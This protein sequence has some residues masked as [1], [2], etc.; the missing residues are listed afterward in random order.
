[1]PLWEPGRKNE[2]RHFAEM[3]RSVLRIWKPDWEFPSTLP[4]SLNEWLDFAAG[5]LCADAKRRVGKEVVTH[6]SEAYAEALRDGVSEA[7]AHA[8]ALTSL[9][10][11]SK[12]QTRF[13]KSYFTSVEF[14]MLS[15]VTHKSGVRERLFAALL[16]VG[17]A[18]INSPISALPL[19]SF[20]SEGK[21]LG[22]CLFLILHSALAAL[23]GACAP[24]VVLATKALFFPFALWCFGAMILQDGVGDVTEGGF[25]I[26]AGNT[27]PAWAL[28]LSVASFIAI[29]F[30]VYWQSICWSAIRK[31]SRIEVRQDRGENRSN[32]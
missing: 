2:F 10:S 7:G 32:G 22:I 29:P 3:Y 24:R 9:G 17:A 8:W 25:F 12:A 4:A 11:A 23:F 14:D 5:D 19:G 6:Y 21:V 27:I 1:M 31:L 30:A 26:V 15:A 20:W 28:V 16:I 18:Y 13:R